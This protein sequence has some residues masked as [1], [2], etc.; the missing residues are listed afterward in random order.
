MGIRSHLEYRIEQRLRRIEEQLHD[1]LLLL[2]HQTREM[3]DQV[4]IRE[5]FRE[6][7]AERQDHELTLLERS[8]A[9]D[10]RWQN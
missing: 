5:L 7:E 10:Q 4:A 3:G 8:A 2:E 9:N 1:M 6:L